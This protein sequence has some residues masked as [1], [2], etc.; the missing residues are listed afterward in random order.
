MLWYLLSKPDDWSVSVSDLMIKGKAG[1]DKI[2]SILAE[3]KDQGYLSRQKQRRDDGTFEWG[4]YYVHEVPVKTDENQPYP[5]KP[6]TDE[7]DTVEPDTVNTEILQNKDYTE[8]VTNVTDSE[9]PETTSDSSTPSAF[10][11]MQEI[12]VNDWFDG[13]WAQAGWAGDIVKMFLGMADK[14]QYAPFNFDSPF[15][16]MDFQA[17]S[18]W[19]GKKDMERPTAPSKLRKWGLEYRKET[20]RRQRVQE[21]QQ[22]AKPGSADLMAVVVQQEATD[23]A[24]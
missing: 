23:A 6:D 22:A 1:R 10:K 8:S 2:Y 4:P 12:V 16:V 15:A 3:L 9:T 5:E 24:A 7:P 11:P 18:K 20:E 21:K 17:F 13:D 14:K 19:L